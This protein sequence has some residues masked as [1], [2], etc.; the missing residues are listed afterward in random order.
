MREN[1]A[2]SQGVARSLLAA[3]TLI[4]E[5]VATVRLTAG[6]HLGRYQILA[7]IGAG[8]MGEVYRARDTKLNRDVALKVL[9]EAFTADPDRL[10]GF[11]REAQVL[12]TLNH[13]H[14]G[15][16]YGFQEFSPSTGSGQ[17]LQA[18]VLELVEGPTCAP[19]VATASSGVVTHWSVRRH[20]LDRLDLG[21][22]SAMR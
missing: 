13:P 10:A 11:K 8:G 16:I 19:S 22:R 5:S 4:L 12:A 7:A 9:P 6:A 20:V 21:A 18:L 3:T 15:A 14:I 1:R 17:A 2:H